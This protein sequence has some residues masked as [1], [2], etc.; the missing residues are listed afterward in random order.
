MEITPP[1]GGGGEGERDVVTKLG[2]VPGVPVDVQRADIFEVTPSGR[3]P[4][5]TDVILKYVCRN[6][7]EDFIYL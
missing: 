1:A 7:L 4:D 6:Y 2:P 5:V 3:E